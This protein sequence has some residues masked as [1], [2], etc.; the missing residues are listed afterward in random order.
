MHCRR[1]VHPKVS[2]C[3]KSLHIV[4][5]FFLSYISQGRT[6]RN[7]KRHLNFMELKFKSRGVEGILWGFLLP[8]LMPAVEVINSV[9]SV[10][11]SNCLLAQ[12]VHVA[13]IA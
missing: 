3:F 12:R 10:C 5:P 9:L 4:Q 8:I 2:K 13:I 11:V 1:R 6:E 7:N